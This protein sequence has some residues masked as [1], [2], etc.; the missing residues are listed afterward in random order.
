MLFGNLY[1]SSKRRQLHQ[2][3]AGSDLDYGDPDLISKDKL[4]QKNAVRRYLDNTIR[5]DWHFSWPDPTAPSPLQKII[6]QPSTTPPPDT[7]QAP[8]QD[9]QSASIEKQAGADDLVAQPVDV[10]VEAGEASSDDDDDAVSTYSTMSEDNDHY[11]RRVDWT[12][13]FS[14]DDEPISP[15]AYRFDS[16]DAVGATVL[17]NELSRAAQRRKAHREEMEWNYGLAWFSARRDAWTEARTVRVRPKPAPATPASQSSRRHSLWRFTSPTTPLSPVDNQALASP[18]SLSRTGTRTS[19]ENSAISSSDSDSK[20]ETG[21]KSS[22]DSSNFPVETLLP[23]A[24]PLLPVANPMRA[25]ITPASYPSIY[26]KIV[27]HSMTPAC[28]INLNDVIK[29]CVVGWKRDGEWPPRAM[30]P[31]ALVAVRRKR[32]D[33]SGTNAGKPNTGRRLSLGGF[34]GRRESAGAHA[35]QQQGAMDATSPAQDDE[36]ATKGIRKSLQRALGF[37]HERNGSAVSNNG[38]VLG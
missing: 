35:E 3:P 18:K 5:T 21:P 27:V 28:P 16:P 15:A 20:G 31:P 8:V 30:D 4:K 36:A 2:Q 25:S 7:V 22:E 1:K 34:L 26:D 12:S 10:D 6:T 19:A 23:I 32:K 14:D 29:S 37:G 17:A 11:R 38:P 24:R 33:S 13:D 9:A